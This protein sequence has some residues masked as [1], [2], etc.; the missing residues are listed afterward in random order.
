MSNDENK[1]KNL[2]NLKKI[3]LKLGSSLKL[4]D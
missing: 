3:E 2:K 1:I 4:V